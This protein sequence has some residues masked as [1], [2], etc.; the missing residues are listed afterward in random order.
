MEGQ[1][2]VWRKV[3]GSAIRCT[4]CQMNE[5]RV[6]T[7]ET[8]VGIEYVCTAPDGNCIFMNCPPDNDRWY[9]DFESVYDDQEEAT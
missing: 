3:K 8:P 2:E 6:L 4:E 5:G 9:P 7:G 1:S